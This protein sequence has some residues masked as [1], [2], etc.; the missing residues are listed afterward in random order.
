M[1]EAAAQLPN[2]HIIKEWATAK[3]ASGTENQKNHWQWKALRLNLEELKISYMVW[4]LC[5]AFCSQQ[6]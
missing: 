1:T 3:I 4:K 5:M 6:R 2:I